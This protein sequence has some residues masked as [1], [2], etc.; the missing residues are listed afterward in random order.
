MSSK[1]GGHGDS[2][3]QRLSA[4]SRASRGWPN[5]GTVR[6]A[7][8]DWSTTGPECVLPRKGN[9]SNEISVLDMLVPI[10]EKKVILK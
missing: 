2:G 10:R 8:L 1:I 6:A 9:A 4:Q 7:P 3:R 5:T